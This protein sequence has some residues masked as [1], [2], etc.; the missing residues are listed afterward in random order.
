MRGRVTD[1]GLIAVEG[2]NARRERMRSWR[3][4][5]D[6]MARKLEAELKQLDH[7]IEVDFID[8]EA[9]RVP[10]SERAPGL[11]PARWHIILRTSAELD[12]QYFPI[13]G[14][15]A[16][17]R[18]PELAIVEEMKARDMW[19][20]GVFDDL[21]KREEKAAAARARQMLTEGEGR[22]EQTA[23]AYRAAKR[24]AGDGGEHRRHDRKGRPDK[25]EGTVPYAGGVSFPTTTTKSGVVLPA[26]AK[27]K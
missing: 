9:A 26:G 6:P 15:N 10:V 1:S 25:E 5:V 18:D 13:L 14:P 27:T 16:A 12:D 23:A 20:K 24:V 17:Y 11:F 3:G 19:R 8:P 22:K 21:M 7:R 4:K 2:R